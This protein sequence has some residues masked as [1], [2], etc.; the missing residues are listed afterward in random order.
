MRASID[1]GVDRAFDPNKKFLNDDASAGFT[2]SAFFHAEAQGLLGLIKVGGNNNTLAERES[3]SLNN[4]GVIGFR[5]K[6]ACRL[7]IRK[8]AIG[9]SR[10]PMPDHKIFGEGFG[11][12]ESG[13]TRSWAEYPEPRILK[14][15]DHPCSQGV[16]GPDDS[17]INLLRL[18]EC[19]QGRDIVS[20]DGH[21]FPYLCCAS[22]AGRSEDFFNFG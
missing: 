19:Q 13:R 9:G 11:R 21:V 4:E 22:I 16:I 8:L 12:F 20:S 10:N 15:V 18:S 1:K 5:A 14:S 17:K 3:V 6:L 7:K 2:K